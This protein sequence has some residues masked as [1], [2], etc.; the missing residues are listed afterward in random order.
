MGLFEKIFQPDKSESQVVLA[1]N[2]GY[3]Q[4]LTAYRPHFT[5]WNGRIYEN[6]MVRAAIDARARHISKLKVEI[7]GTAKPSLQAK[8]RLAP[9]QWQTWSQFLYRVSTIL[10]V[11]NNC[12]V[13]PVFDRDLVITGYYPVLPHRC[14]IISYDGEPWLLYEFS[15]GQRAAVELRLCG[16][17]TKHQYKSDFFGDSNDA[18]DETMKVLH[19]Q[20][21]GIEEAVKS[22]ATYRFMATLNNF[23]TNEDL[24]KRRKEFTE[25]N[26]RKD[27]DNDGLLLW[28]NNFHDIKQIEPKSYTLNAEEMTYIKNNVMEYFGVSQKV[29]ENA[30]QSD[31]LDAFFNGCVEPFCIQFSEVMTMAIFT[32]RE[33][34]QG[35]YLIANAN[36]LQY[37]STSAKVQMA[38]ELADRGIVMIDEIRELFNMAPLPNGAGQHVPIRGEYYMQDEREE[39]TNEE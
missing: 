20:N 8:L 1:N 33:R 39:T 17:L 31:E 26:F 32:E 15:N 35:S 10:D 23:T 13:C 25:Q 3:F 19:L 34:A 29:M 27:K 22:G 4:T 12:I 6:E 14:K 5:T 28:P 11:E 16:I 18:L 9:N 36:R 38:K 30:A 7:M 21:E 24:E 2:D 37:M